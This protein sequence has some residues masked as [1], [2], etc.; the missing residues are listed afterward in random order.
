MIPRHFQLQELLSR[1]V[2][3]VSVL[4]GEVLGLQLASVRPEEF[5]RPLVGIVPVTRQR[6]RLGYVSDPDH[7][8]RIV[9][10]EFGPGHGP[11]GF[12]QGIEW[13]LDYK[14]EVRVVSRGSLQS[15]EFCIVGSVLKTQE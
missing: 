8:S 2:G 7:Q 1:I 15:P 10:D 4:R 11:Q 3:G 12:V 6:S 5:L 14:T 9:G 13:L